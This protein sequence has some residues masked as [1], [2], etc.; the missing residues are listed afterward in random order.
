L[1]VH[2]DVANNH[3]K[4]LYLFFAATHPYFSDSHHCKDLQRL[5]KVCH[6]RSLMF[7]HNLSTKHIIFLSQ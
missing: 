5:K 1:H 2:I 4:G 6:D 7:L 3:A